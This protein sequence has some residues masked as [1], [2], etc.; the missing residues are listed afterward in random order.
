VVV[1]ILR[2]N[3]GSDHILLSTVLELGHHRNVSDDNLEI[4][5][6]ATTELFR[7]FDSD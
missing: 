5:K 2:H 3:E 4:V 1:G 7:S 6:H